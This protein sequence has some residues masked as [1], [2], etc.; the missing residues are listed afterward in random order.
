MGFLDILNVMVCGDSGFCYILFTCFEY[1]VDLAGLCLLGSSLNLSLPPLSWARLLAVC[2]AFVSSGSARDLVRIHKQS[3]KHP[4]SGSVLYRNPPLLPSGISHSDLPPLSGSSGWKGCWLLSVFYLP[5][6]APTSAFTQRR[7]WK[8]GNI[9]PC[10]F[11]F[12]ELTPLQN[13]VA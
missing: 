5:Y 6:V 11:H 3:L 2:P 9:S 1:T 4:H 13:L 12:Q 10:Y 8:H 7:S